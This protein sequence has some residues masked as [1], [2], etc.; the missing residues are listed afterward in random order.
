MCSSAKFQESKIF[1]GG[2]TKQ[3]LFDTLRPCTIQHTL[4]LHTRLWPIPPQLMPHALR[5]LD[6][7]QISLWVLGSTRSDVPA[8]QPRCRTAR[9][10][11][12]ASLVTSVAAKIPLDSTGPA[13]GACVRNRASICGKREVRRHLTVDVFQGGKHTSRTATHVAC[14]SAGK[15]CMLPDTGSWSPH[16]E[17]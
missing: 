11:R 14:V 8:W 4:H 7:A 9:H 10:G 12:I 2:D 13:H 3:R 15:R 17:A 6:G 5:P 16:S 1:R